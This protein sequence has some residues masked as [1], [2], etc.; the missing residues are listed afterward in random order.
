[1]FIRQRD[2]YK[3]FSLIIKLIHKIST[4]IISEN[5]KFS[6][7]QKIRI[8]AKFLRTE[9]KLFVHVINFVS[10]TSICIYE[11]FAIAVIS[12]LIIINYY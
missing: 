12:H 11:I 3:F 8:F 9:I 6:R 4:S 1:M 5:D 2:W 7:F 10:I